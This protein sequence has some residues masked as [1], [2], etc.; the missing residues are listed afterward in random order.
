[1]LLRAPHR[2]VPFIFKSLSNLQLLLSRTHCVGPQRPIS[3][4]CSV[5]QIIPHVKVLLCRSPTA[6]AKLLSRGWFENVL[7]HFTTYLQ[8]FTVHFLTVTIN[9]SNILYHCVLVMGENYS[10]EPR[11]NFNW[12][13]NNGLSSKISAGCKI[14]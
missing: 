5:L 2:R 4:F 10:L 14:N 11:K 13:L 7:Y 3:L 1:M 6:W 9:Y 12:L 8:T